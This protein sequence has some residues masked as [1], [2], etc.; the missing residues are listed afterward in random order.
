M[1][2]EALYDIDFLLRLSNDA[3]RSPILRF[4]E[5]GNCFLI[6]KVK[7]THYALFGF[8]NVDTSKSPLLRGRILK[9][10]STL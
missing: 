5:I 1:Q 4:Q 8:T 10:S 9:S 3:H 7:Q 2:H 6:G